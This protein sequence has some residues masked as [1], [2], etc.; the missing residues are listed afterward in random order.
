MKTLLKTASAIAALCLLFTSHASS[1]AGTDAQSR[2]PEDPHLIWTASNVVLVSKQLADGV[3]AVYPDDAEA[4]NAQ[5]IPAAT[6]GGFV[7]GSKG[8][9][10]VESMLNRRLAGQMLKLVRAQ[11]RK[12]ILYLVNTSY[13]GDH[14]YGNQFFPRTAQV[15]QHTNTQQY[16]QSH[17]TDDIAFME[18]YFGKNQGLDELKPQRADVLLQDGARIEIDLGGPVVQVMHLGFAQT[19][20]DLFVYLPKEKV[21]FTGNPIISGGPS[22]PWLLDGRLKDS[23]STMKK[24]RALLP[25]DAQVVPGHGAP[26]SV[27][28]V[29]YPIRY[30]EE[31]Q[32][33]VG[34]AVKQGLNEKDTVERVT[35]EMHEYAGYKIFPW[36]HSQVNIP[37]T[38]QEMKKAQTGQVG[39]LMHRCATAMGATATDCLCVQKAEPRIDARKVACPA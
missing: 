6:S 13:H 5:G 15:V 27:A 25:G 28:A 20:G 17:F 31:L 34:A 22:L 12:P 10:V 14:S 24:L 38:Y 18:Q 29:D 32:E 36:I 35:N 9:L 11:T 16:I 3:F 7:V 23:L 39:L 30:L 37:K 4:K 1:A 26:T 33:R 8:V 2:T 19:V 21:L